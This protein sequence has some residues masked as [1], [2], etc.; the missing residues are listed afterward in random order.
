[1]DAVRTERVF[2]VENGRTFWKLGGSGKS[3]ILAQGLHCSFQH[4]L[5]H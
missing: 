5:F 3:D 4:L 2:I 1:M